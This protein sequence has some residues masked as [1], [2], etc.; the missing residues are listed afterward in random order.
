MKMRISLMAVFGVICMIL[1][2]GCGKSGSESGAKGA[3]AAAPAAAAPA[4]PA[5]AAKEKV[6][7]TAFALAAATPLSAEDAAIYKTIE[8]KSSNPNKVIWRHGT[9]GRN[10]DENPNARTDRQLFIEIKKRLGDKVEFQFYFGGTLGTSADAILGGLQAR[11][12]ESYFYNVGA[13]AEYTKAFLPLDVMYLVPDEISGIDICE[14]EPGEIMRQ[15]CIEDSGLNV[16]YYAAIGMR[17]I[18]NSKKPIKTPD[19]LKGMKIRTQNNPLHIMAMQEL[20]ASPTPIA[21]AELFTALQ[22]GVVDGQE[23]PIINIYDMNY[24]EVQKYM[25][26]TNHLYTAGATVVNDKWLK[27]QSAEFQKA[28]KDSLVI[29]NAYNKSESQNVESKLLSQLGKQMEVYV[30]T[31]A[32]N[33]QFKDIS[34]RTWDKAAEKMGVDYFNKVRA[35]MDKVIAAKKK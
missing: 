34:M 29:T 8:A 27:S 35:S 4:A 11:S 12:F 9:V 22:Q 30:L 14:G 7:L 6:D 32:E 21:F 10:L 1:F 15:K 5:P 26:I 16:L 23:N 28:V 19:D 18:T 3:T 2:M 31:D 33:K 20:G 17:H 13:F 25:S 24:G